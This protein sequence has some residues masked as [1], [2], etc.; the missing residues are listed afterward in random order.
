MPSIARRTHMH[1]RTYRPTVGECMSLTM[2][3]DYNSLAGRSC[4]SL[5]SRGLRDPADYNLLSVRI[6]H[7]NCLLAAWLLRS[8]Y[9]SISFGL[10]SRFVLS[11]ARIGRRWLLSRS[12]LG[13][14]L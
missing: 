6:R 5:L 10:I 11:L 13:G 8:R 9:S 2:H 1:M 14:V 3:L 4:M 12:F 7:W